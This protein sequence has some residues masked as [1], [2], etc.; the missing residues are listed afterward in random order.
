MSRQI[1]LCRVARH[2]RA[3]FTR[4]NRLAILKAI[5]TEVA[6]CPQRLALV[7][8]PETLRAI[9]QHLD[10]VLAGDGQYAIQIGGAAFD[11]HSHDGFG[12]G[13]DAVLDVVGVYVQR[14]INLGEYGE[15]PGQH[16]GV[17]AGIPCPGGQNHLIA[18]AN[19]KSRHGDH[20]RGRPRRDPQHIAALHALREFLFESGALHG[21]FGS[22]PVPAKRVAGGHHIADPSPLLVIVKLRSHA[23]F[24]RP[25]RLF[26]HRLAPIDG[27][28]G[29]VRRHHGRGRRRE[30]RLYPR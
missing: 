22:G 29:C 4:G 19:L 8:C 18:G 23:T 9:F 17:V 1:N 27:E 26:A 2:H 21:L 5:D 28:G 14:S 7:T 11:V 20:E 25:Q 6:N 3:A 15:R 16:N 13:P 10:S 24:G 30:R 12:L